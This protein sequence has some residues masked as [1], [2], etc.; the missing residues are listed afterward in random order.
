MVAADL[1]VQ[2]VTT[3]LGKGRMVQLIENHEVE[4]GR[5]GLFGQGGLAMVIG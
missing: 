4:R 1:V 2:Q 3:G 5:A